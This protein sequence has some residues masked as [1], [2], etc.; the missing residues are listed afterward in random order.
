MKASSQLRFF[1]KESMVTFLEEGH[2]LLLSGISLLSLCVFAFRMAGIF[3]R[4]G[5]WSRSLCPGGANRV[6]RTI[7]ISTPTGVDIFIVRHDEKFI[8]RRGK[9]C[10]AYQM[11][12]IR[13]DSSLWEMCSDFFF[14]MALFL[15]EMHSAAALCSKNQMDAKCATCTCND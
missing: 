13:T 15:V 4:W 3:S 6:G 5:R 10:R 12:E 1:S 8:P 9:S 2:H 7:K 14:L 11:Q